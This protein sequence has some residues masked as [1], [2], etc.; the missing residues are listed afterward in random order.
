MA[1]AGFPLGSCGSDWATGGCTTELLGME[2]GKRVAEEIWGN[3]LFA[4]V[5]Y[6]AFG[7]LLAAG[8]TSLCIFMMSTLMNLVPSLVIPDVTLI[9]IITGEVCSKG[10]KKWCLW[11]RQPERKLTLIIWIQCNVCSIWKS[12]VKKQ[13]FSYFPL[14]MWMFIA[15]LLYKWSCSAWSR[16]CNICWGKHHNSEEIRLAPWLGTWKCSLCKFLSRAP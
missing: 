16:L 4:Y 5:L 2:K 7:K 6:L 1:L 13:D 12:T 14:L 9:D 8:A 15:Q 10:P 11:D 3:G